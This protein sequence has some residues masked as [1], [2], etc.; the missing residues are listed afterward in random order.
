LSNKEL[1]AR[2][3]DLSKALNKELPADLNQ[4]NNEALEALVAELEKATGAS[5]S[6]P[7]SD[8]P[9]VAEAPTVAASGA[10]YFVP[11]GKSLS[12]KRGVLGPGAEVFPTDVTGLLNDVEKPDPAKLL[13]AQNKQLEFLAGRGHLNKR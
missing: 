4:L 11:A 6:T 7:P 1:R 13:E 3:T 9:P 5:Q 12:G 2:V 8:D 10:R